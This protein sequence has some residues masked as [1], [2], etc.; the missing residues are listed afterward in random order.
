MSSSELLVRIN[1]LVIQAAHEGCA[2]DA[3]LDVVYDAL[4]LVFGPPDEE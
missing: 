3:I 2:E 1:E 4:N